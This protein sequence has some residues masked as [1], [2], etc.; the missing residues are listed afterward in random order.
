MQLKEIEY[1]IA[2]TV[3]VNEYEPAKYHVSIKAD[4][5][6]KDDISESYNKLRKIVQDQIRQDF[7]RVRPSMTS[8]EKYAKEIKKIK[9]VKE[10]GEY[11]KKNKDK[12]KTLEFNKLIAERKKE[13]HEGL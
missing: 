5:T 10:L 11:Y 2:L 7:E 1:G 8:Q 13:I 9:G 6:E 12:Y 3:Q 4:I